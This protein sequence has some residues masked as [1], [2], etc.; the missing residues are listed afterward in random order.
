M[1][2]AESRGLSLQSVTRRVTN[3]SGLVTAVHDTSVETIIVAAGTYDLTNSTAGVC[4]SAVHRIRP[5]SLDFDA[6]YSALCITDRRLSII[7]ETNGTV[8]LNATRQTWRVIYVGGGG[9]AE[10]VGLTIT[11]GFASEGGG[12]LIAGGGQ[13]TLTACAIT[14]NAA[15]TRGGGLEIW[16]GGGQATL[17]SCTISENEA[18][19]GGG[20]YI[21]D[22]GSV[23]MTDCV[24][25]GNEAML[26]Y[27]GGGLGVGQASAFLTSCTISG[28]AAAQGGGL[29]IDGTANLTSCTISGN[30]ARMSYFDATGQFGG[31]G[32]LK[33]D[34]FG[35]ATLTSC[36]ISGNDATNN[37]G[38]G[39]GV[40]GDA[41]LS[42][43]VIRGNKAS[44]GAGLYLIGKAKMSDCMIAGNSAAL[45]GGGLLM[46]AHS[47]MYLLSSTVTL[48]EADWSGGGLHLEAS[49]NSGVF[50]QVDR[51]S[52][53]DRPQIDHPGEIG[54]SV[55]VLGS[56]V[57][58][59]TGDSMFVSNRAPAGSNV[60]NQGNA[61]V[62]L[63]P[64]PPGT[65][66][67]H[68]YT[69]DSSCV[70]VPR[71]QPLANLALIEDADLPYICP[72]GY[73][74]DGGERHPCPPGKRGDGTGFSNSQCGGDCP[75]GRYCPENSTAPLICPGGTFSE[76]GSGECA[77]CYKGHWCSG[78][79]AF[80]CDEGSYLPP[81][82]PQEDRT[83]PNVCR[84]CGPHGTTRGDGMA[85]MSSCFCEAGFYDAADGRGAL[86][87]SGC[88]IG[89]SC[90]AG[91]ISLSTLP[92]H[93]GYFRP[94]AAS[95]DLRRCPDAS[96]S[97]Q[98]S[99]CIGGSDPSSYCVSGLSGPF[100]RL[101]AEPRGHYYETAT[102]GRPSSCRSCGKQLVLTTL[103]N[104]AGLLLLAALAIGV[105]TMA[106][107]RLLPA[108]QRR[109][110]HALALTATPLKILVGFYLVATKVPSV[111]HAN[112]PAP[113]VGVLRAFEV[114]I[115]FGLSGV[116][117]LLSCAGA[118]GYGA[119]LGF[120]AL[121][122]LVL[123]L[124][125]LAATR[126]AGRS[127]VQ[128]AL[129]VALRLLFLL[130]PTVTQVAFEAF[131][132]Y[133]LGLEDEPRVGRWLIVDVSVECGS[134]THRSLLLCAWLAIGAYSVGLLV[135]YAALLLRA[136]QAIVTR[137][138][139][140]LSEALRFLHH[141][142]S[143]E[144]Y[145]WELAEMARRLVLVGFL[146]PFA[147]GSL[148]QLACGLM[149]AVIYLLLQ[150]QARPYRRLADNYLA[151][152]ASFSL[153]VLLFG[154]LLL[155]V[156]DVIEEAVL[157]SHVRD[158]LALQPVV[159]TAALL[160]SVVGSML[161]AA[162][163]LAQQLAEERTRLV[164][165]ARAARTRRL[166]HR[167]GGSEVVM[168]PIGDGDFHLFLSH[169][170]GT[171]QDQMRVVKQRLTE[172]L[173]DVK[174]FLDVDDLQRR[175]GKGAELV[176]RC[177]HFLV[178]CSGGFFSSPNCIRELVCAVLRG[179]PI[180]ALMEPDRKHGRLTTVEAKQGLLEAVARYD[181][182][183][184]VDEMRGWGFE[185]LPGVDELYD[186]VFAAERI[187]WDRIGVFQDVS[188]RLLAER[189]LPLP[190]RGATHLQDELTCH[191]MSVPPPRG[192]RRFHLFCCADNAGALELASE[193]GASLGQTLEVTFDVSEVAACERALL[194]LNGKTW[195]SGDA[196]GGD[197]S[198][199]ALA[200]AVEAAMEAGVGLLLAHECLG[201]GIQEARHGV[202]F[203]DVL[204][205]T[206][207]ALL[208]RGVYHQIAIAFKG[209]AWR[210]V[211]MRMLAQ[212]L[213]ATEIDGVPA[214]P[215]S[216]SGR[217]LPVRWRRLQD[218][219]RRRVAPRH[220]STVGP[221]PAASPPLVKPLHRGGNGFEPIVLNS[222]C[223]DLEGDHASLAAAAGGEL[224]LAPR[225]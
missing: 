38:G 80:A 125:V 17:T 35:K 40:L 195:T 187:V 11:G 5:S 23:T 1:P 159:I 225:D 104:G 71:A 74:C 12:L 111:Y 27:G 135:T 190:L 119:R 73:W 137:Q 201:E 151:M 47:S 31:A 166:R 127:L 157:P 99:G 155:R 210:E 131:S 13:A 101:C 87:C 65:Y 146:V 156:G 178:F 67:P 24:I 197:A 126:L 76:K 51:R 39:F 224:E 50:P 34:D 105:L 136:R 180:I 122:P 20:L 176:A 220:T 55:V 209:G 169:A 121:L 54:V 113:V 81:D 19:S 106:Y 52:T 25:S 57:A 165:E 132:C 8:V 177:E 213:V 56:G 95:F 22:S 120:W 218:V 186:A 154:A 64:T 139:T 181:E 66:L 199:G 179:K 205:A 29:L 149:V 90:S 170:W 96:V 172:M 217:V 69:C 196:S 194:Y 45:Q 46:K 116:S 141:E 16:K 173:P 144:Y 223:Q 212:E 160:A 215:A 204:G 130:Y 62:Y 163:V 83:T 103:R 15:Y 211:S 189:L 53:A 153:V 107:R 33:I 94:S 58:L 4:R 44:Y 114:S 30:V 117:T 175:Q 79:E 28:N 161:V 184:L 167:A 26:G 3:A 214:L 85:S 63:L 124:V 61:T 93:S 84:S 134:G 77:P 112:L 36:T 216:P 219:L 110:G 221:L 145:F 21:G 102:H 168:P 207:Q 191:E 86:Q 6:W 2:L 88:P 59:I 150:L 152:T 72:R 198:G 185:S 188:L 203:E 208:A 174:V 183:G 41:T 123:A 162:L 140:A 109:M 43:C 200:L 118:P 138:P 222:P 7:A 158:L 142:Y 78:G 192:G 48:N 60:A 100:C 147:P 182:W 18:A 32:G 10:L 89:A 92:L 164:Q 91:A 171:G 42:S 75:A 70:G 14:G 202:E 129:P 108:S 82:T 97:A 128:S 68:K 37:Y 9:R 49:H 98:L 148:Q 193:L 143:V 115:S 206:P 133:D